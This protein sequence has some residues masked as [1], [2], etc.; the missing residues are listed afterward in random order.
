VVALGANIKTLTTSPLGKKVIG[1]DK[2]F[3]ATRKLMKVLIPG[4]AL[5]IT[6]KTLKPL[7][8]VM[9]RLERV[10]VVA[11]YENNWPPPIAVY[12]EGAIDEAE[13]VKAATSYSEAEN[14]PF[15]TSKIGDRKLIVVDEGS[16]KIHG[17]QVHKSLYLVATSRKLIDDV[18]DKHA[19][20]K[21]G[22]LQPVRA[23]WL[24]KARPAETPLWLALGEVEDVGGL[25]GVITIALKDDA[26]FRLEAVSKDERSAKTIKE[27]LDYAVDFVNRTDRPQGKL[28]AAARVAVT[29]DGLTVKAAG[30]IPGKLLAED[31]AKQK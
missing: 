9:N 1:A 16:T 8:P 11:T 29:L 21:K 4:D 28:W 2:P 20:K 13:F 12:L 23:D 7:E 10:T 31:Y 25:N 24:K 6:D 26:E 17:I 19:G 3:D 15:S 22:T 5:P 18:L 30:A 27:V 14:K